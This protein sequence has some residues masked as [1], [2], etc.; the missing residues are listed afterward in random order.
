MARAMFLNRP[1]TPLLISARRALG[2][3]QVQVS[4]ELGVSHRT[5]AR[6]ERGQATI[7]VVRACRL[8]RLVFPRD[9][10]LAAELASAA[11]ESLES[12]GLVATPQAPPPPPL[13][14]VIDAVVCVAADALG[15]VPSTVRPAL[16]A[17]FRRARELGLSLDDVEKALAPAATKGS[18]P[19]GPSR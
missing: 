9:A 14:L 13:P 15:A 11:S 10:S 18:K 8:A 7:D 12:L 1:I 3:S 16:H 17:A 2:L 19:S 4:R 5:V 6:W